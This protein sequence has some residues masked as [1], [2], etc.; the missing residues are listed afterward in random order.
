MRNWMLLL[1]GVTACR[2]AASAVREHAVEVSDS[3]QAAA[4]IDSLEARFLAA[5]NRDDHAG[6]AETY[7]PDVRFVLEGITVE[8]RVRLE[9]AWK[10]QVAAL[11]G[12]KFTTVDRVISGDIGLLTQRFA[13]QE[14]APDGKTVIDSGYA[15][16]LVRLDPDGQW[17]YHTVVL[18]RPPEH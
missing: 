14:R 1:L 5:Y 18:S 4:G 12:L 17:R 16:S 8:G 11:N 6:I 3:T 2:P 15:V 13:Q 9:E 7:S 10:E